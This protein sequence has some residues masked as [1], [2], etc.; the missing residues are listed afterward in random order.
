[1]NHN[2]ISLLLKEAKEDL[3]NLREDD[4]VYKESEKTDIFFSLLRE[5]KFSKEAAIKK[6]KIILHEIP[7]K[8]KKALDDREDFFC[9]FEYSVDTDRN[10]FDRT[11]AN[12]VLYRT[13]DESIMKALEEELISGNINYEIVVEEHDDYSRTR[14]ANLS[15]WK[16]F[17]LII[18]F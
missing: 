8:I 2:E 7:A 10:F 5:K 9:L 11:H 3:I 6:S 4:R 17:L 16:T 13:Y 12:N 14:M 1:M 18:K 15:Y